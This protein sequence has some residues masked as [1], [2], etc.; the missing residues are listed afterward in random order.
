MAYRAAK[1]AANQVTVTFA[2]EWEKEGRNVTI[3]CMEPG[4]LSTGLTGWDGVDDMETCVRGIVEVV[5]GLRRSDNGSF[6][7][8]DGSKIA[9]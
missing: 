9:F 7:K 5:D 3:V 2:R 8:W 1:A 6:V 4:F